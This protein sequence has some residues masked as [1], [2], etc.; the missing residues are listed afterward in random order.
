MGDTAPELQLHPSPR[1]C[2]LSRAFRSEFPTARRR[3]MAHPRMILARLRLRTARNPRPNPGVMIDVAIPSAGPDATVVHMYTT[4]EPYTPLYPNIHYVRLVWP[5][6]YK[7]TNGEA[8]T[9]CGRTLGA[10]IKGY[11]PESLPYGKEYE[12]DAVQ[13]P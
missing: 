11:V 7:R 3:M 12:R 2:S 6:V 8:R 4:V 1:A 10:L 13:H 5:P 9:D